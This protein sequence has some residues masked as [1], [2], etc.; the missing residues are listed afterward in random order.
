MGAYLKGLRLAKDWK[1]AAVARRAKTSRPEVTRWEN[2]PTPPSPKMLARLVLALAGTDEVFI[3]FNKAGYGRQLA[4]LTLDELQHGGPE[5]DPLQ[6]IEDA[7][8]AG[9]WPSKVRVSLLTL[10]RA[11]CGG[12]PTPRCARRSVTTVT[13]PTSSQST[14]A[15]TS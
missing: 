14:G 2:S 4:A 11:W 8:L 10:A 6:A 5:I 1:Q 7:L 13:S 3:A 9:G 15:W 12:F